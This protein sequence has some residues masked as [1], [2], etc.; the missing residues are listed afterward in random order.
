[1]TNNL[2]AV[3]VLIPTHK[4]RDLYVERLLVSLREQT[5]MDFD[6]I[7]V[8][9]DSEKSEIPDYAQK[10]YGFEITYIIN[11]TDLGPQA[12][13]EKGL[14]LCKAKYIKPIMS[15]D[16]IAPT[17]LEETYRA[18]ENNTGAVMAFGRRVLIDDDDTI[19]KEAR[20]YEY[21]KL[22]TG[23]I[24]GK[25]LL[26]E[27]IN[28]L[29]WFPGEP[30]NFLIRN[31]IVNWTGIFKSYN[32]PSRLSYRGSFDL[33]LYLKLLIRGDAYYINKPL[34]YIREHESRALTRPFT[35][36]LCHLD[37]YHFAHDAYKIGIIGRDDYYETIARIYRYIFNILIRPGNMDKNKLLYLLGYIYKI[38]GL[39][40]EESTTTPDTEF[41]NCL[42]EMV[43]GSSEMLINRNVLDKLIETN[44]RVYGYGTGGYTRKLFNDNHPVIPN[45]IGFIDSDKGKS[46][47][48]LFGKPVYHIEEV[49][50]STDEYILILSALNEEI[51]AILEDKGY[52]NVIDFCWL[53]F[54][55]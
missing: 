17:F 48:E 13:M 14:T 9:N 39:I 5:F 27:T 46:G 15:D 12:N 35:G 49:N 31:G 25:L 40:K 36:T 43:F 44:T 1:M 7:I 32:A 26:K 55:G 24:D 19:I 10:E 54:S 30:S 42:L 34:S 38:M 4:G 50:P 21:S 6:V 41:E 20:F 33:I 11:E 3:N 16:L 18:L 53:G 23:V 29:D 47:T 52:L 37:Y 22:R 28:K 2:P 45:I 51:A 8:D